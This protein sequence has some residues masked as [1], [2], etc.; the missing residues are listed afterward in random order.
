M[1]TIPNPNHAKLQQVSILVAD[2]ACD[3]DTCVKVLH[4]LYMLLRNSQRFVS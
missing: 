1:D 4:A 3:L 2:T